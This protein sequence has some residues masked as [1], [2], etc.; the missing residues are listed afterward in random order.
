M[1]KLLF[2]DEPGPWRTGHDYPAV[3][4]TRVSVD[5]AP[6]KPLAY[7][8]FGHVNIDFDGSPTAYA[9]PGKGLVSDDDLSNAYDDNRWFGVVALSENDPAVVSGQA[10][11]DKRPELE[12]GGKYPVIQQAAN[13]DPNPGYYVSSLP[14][15][16]GPAYRQDSYIDASQ[17]AFGAL[18]G[19]L[20]ALGVA[21]GDYGLAI[22]HDKDA[23]SGFFFADVGGNN[24][25]LGECSHKVG[26][27]LGGSGRGNR[28]NNNFPVSFIVFP[29][30]RTQETGTINA[31]SDDQ[32]A[33]SLKQLLE[34]LSGV[35]NADELILLMGFNETPPPE[36]PQGL[37]KLERY[38]QSPDDG[39]QPHSYDTIAKA[40]SNWGYILRSS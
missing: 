24:Y 28:F 17:V 33:Q 30:S 36:K 3:S 8:F 20:K 5:D 4:L 31:E 35:D 21:L 22:R 1:S 6:D 2:Q 39:Q 19:R 13:D 10:I 9:P 29:Q 7:V 38:V 15:A 32:I 23:Q 14:Y 25:A 37:S 12:R 11:I 26:K 34:T 16:S 40:L 18:S 27:D